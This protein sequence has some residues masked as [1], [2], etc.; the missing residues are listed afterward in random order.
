MSFIY[1]FSIR[2]LRK[3]LKQ[4]LYVI[5]ILQCKHKSECIYTALKFAYS[6][7][8]YNMAKTKENYIYQNMSDNLLFVRLM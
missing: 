4:F 8:V 7:F 6:T 3:K 2:T 5:S 1:N